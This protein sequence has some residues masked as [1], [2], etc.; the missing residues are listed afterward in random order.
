MTAPEPTPPNPFPCPY[1]C[2]HGRILRRR[3]DGRVIEDT[4]LNC[5]GSGTAA[6]RWAA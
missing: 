3:E 1:C 6:Q 5:G 4:C 2:G